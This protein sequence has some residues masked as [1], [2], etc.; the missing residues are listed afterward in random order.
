MPATSTSV[1]TRFYVRTFS[2]ALSTYSYSLLLSLQDLDLECGYLWVV[3]RR[4][5][6]FLLYVS[7]Y[8]S[9]YEVKTE[10]VRS[11]RNLKKESVGFII[12]FK[13]ARARIVVFLLFLLI[14]SRFY[15]LNIVYILVCIVDRL[16]TS[17]SKQTK[18]VLGHE[19]SMSI[20]KDW[21]KMPK[22]G[23]GPGK[24]Q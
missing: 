21:C 18:R 12:R 20:Q 4:K 3:D 11:E 13:R 7:Y 2:S 14:V 15:C 8:V 9:R 22:F 23:M 6:T 16:V 17:P 5:Q 19:G 24:A 1:W 10:K